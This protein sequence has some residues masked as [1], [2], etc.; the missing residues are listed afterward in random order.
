M[1]RIIV[2]ALCAGIFVTGISLSARAQI[3][4]QQLSSVGKTAVAQGSAM[5]TDTLKSQLKDLAVRIINNQPQ[6]AIIS[7]WKQIL[8]GN[9]N[10]NVDAAL[11]YI[12][13]ALRASRPASPPDALVLP[14]MKTDNLIKTMKDTAAQFLQTPK[15][16]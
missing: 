16:K 3:N 13:Q 10:I 6:A 14:D 4:S 11:E 1:V 12:K 2:V 7:Q 9:K 8:T 5:L 15:G